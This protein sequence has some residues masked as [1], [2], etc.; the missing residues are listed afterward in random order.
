DDAIVGIVTGAR[1]RRR[2]E[3]RIAR[4]HAAGRTDLG[5]RG[6]VELDVVPAGVEI[7][8]LVGVRITVLAERDAVLA[9]AAANLVVAGVAFD[10]VGPAIAAQ[11]I[12]A[13]VA[14]HG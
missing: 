14:I 2:I 9:G 3:A 7:G 5:E 12:V 11:R 6:G 4:S 1:S 10:P 8:Q 13:R